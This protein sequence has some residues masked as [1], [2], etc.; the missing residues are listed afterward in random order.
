MIGFDAVN[1]VIIYYS[2]NLTKSNEIESYGYKLITNRFDCKIL[3]IFDFKI[4]IKRFFT[5]I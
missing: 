5:N 1:L 2:R 4:L 3:F